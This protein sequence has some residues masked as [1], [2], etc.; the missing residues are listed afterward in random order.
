MLLKEGES[1]RFLFYKQ[2]DL[3]GEIYWVVLAPND[4]KHLIEARYY[5]P[6]LLQEGNYYSCKVEKISCTGKV[7]LE[8]HHPHY[9]EGAVYPFKIVEHRKIVNS[10]GETETFIRVKDIF[11]R[12]AQAILPKH[13]KNSLLEEIDLKVERIRNGQLVLSVPIF[14]GSYDH[15]QKGEFYQFRITGLTSIG[16]NREF[17]VLKDEQNAL[18]YLRKKFY[19]DYQFHKG[20]R[21]RALIIQEPVRGK[22]YLEPAYPDYEIGKEYEFTFLREAEFQREDKTTRQIFIVA[23]RHDKECYLFYHTDVPPPVIDGKIKAKVNY[24]R[25]GK[26]FLDYSGENSLSFN[27]SF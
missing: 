13:L 4:K 7:K 5:E 20:D 8:P 21:I 16:E 24:Y 22:Y 27:P 15:L 26:L 18:H 23:D 11:G 25:R 14:T 10:W 1:Y 3:E 12:E 9:R 6:Y 2:V 17:F 19:E